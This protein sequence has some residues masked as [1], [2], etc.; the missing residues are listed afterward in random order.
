M[1]SLIWG[2]SKKRVGF[3]AGQC[4]A[5]VVVV[6]LIFG[7]GQASAATVTPPLLNFGQVPVGATA[8]I[9]LTAV[10]L[11][12][13]RVEIASGTGL[14]LP[15]SFAF[16]ACSA[17]TCTGTEGF[18]PTS[19]GPVSATLDIFECPIAGGS[20]VGTPVTVEGIGV[21]L[22]SPFA[23]DFGAQTTSTASAISWLTVQNLSSSLVAITAPATISGPNASDFTIPAG[24]DDC[25]GRTLA[26]EADCFVGVRFT[27]GAV[28]L[29]SATLT[30]GQVAPYSVLVP[31]SLSGTGV[32]PNSGPTGPAGASG[33]NG[34]VELV[35]CSPVV[36]KKGKKGHA[37]AKKA[38]RCTTNL[39]SG[40]V[41]F[42]TTGKA[43]QATFS[44]RGQLVATGIAAGPAGRTLLLN[45][46]QQ[47]PPGRYTL[48]LSHHGQRT[49]QTV[50]IG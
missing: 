50:L 27:P 5:I 17:G 38:L 6:A 44:R 30:V 3:V 40:P 19:A 39:V 43:A 33:T 41:K 16:G 35:S 49:T 36:R 10:P 9:S 47:L 4:G 37:S 21:P 15:F 45:P 14:N 23:L 7:A 48:Q 13:Y 25:Q 26:A 24:A 28:G 29:R 12:G 11:P 31:V 8:T 22:H 1:L 46:G 20:C 18:K 42:T 32:A 2:Y 34:Q